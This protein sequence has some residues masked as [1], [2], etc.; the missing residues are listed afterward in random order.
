MNYRCVIYMLNDCVLLGLDW[1][2]PMMY[3]SLHVTY[4]RIFRAYIPSILY[5]L[6]YWCSLVLFCVFLSLS[7]S[8]SLSLALACS[9]APKCKS[10]PS[11]NPLRSGAS[12]SSPF[13]PTLSHVQF[14][15]DKARKDFL[16]N[17]FR[18]GIHLERQVI[19]R[20]F[21]ILTFPLS[22]TIGVGSHCVASRS[23]ALPWS[24]RSFTP[25][26]TELIL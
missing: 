14:H 23:R 22:S 5:I 24:Y 11:W 17:F 6:I 2:E 10:T 15:D 26:C 16:E 4:S 19:Y 8:L 9:M 3:L 13:D 18:W 7:L 20:I 1:V 12:S 21:P 25:T